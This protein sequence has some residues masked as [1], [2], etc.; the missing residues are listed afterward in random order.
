MSKTASKGEP[1]K[2]IAKEAMSL[3]PAPSTVP[4]SNE[5]PEEERCSFRNLSSKT[6]SK[7]ISVAETAKEAEKAFCEDLSEIAC[8]ELDNSPQFADEIILNN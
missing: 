8:K 6:L 3:N 7:N 2:T 1:D 4:S 5:E